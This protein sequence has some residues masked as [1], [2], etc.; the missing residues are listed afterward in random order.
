MS[1]DEKQQNDP[2]SVSS[3]CYPPFPDHAGSLELQ[4]NEFTAEYST[5]AKWIAD[6]D[7]I[8]EDG[9]I[10][11]PEWESAAHKQRAIDSNEVWTL[12][13]YPN[14]PIGFKY[15][16]APTYDELLKFAKSCA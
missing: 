3:H 1:E 11:I 13:W 2:G 4:H 14:T 6:C 9:G 8:G 12:H 16:A 10:A 15:I 7:E 5:A